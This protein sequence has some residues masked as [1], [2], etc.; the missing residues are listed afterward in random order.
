MARTPPLG[1][2]ASVAVC[3][4]PV[5]QHLHL[6]AVLRHFASLAGTVS[7]VLGDGLELRREL[8]TWHVNCRCIDQTSVS[9]FMGL[10]GGSV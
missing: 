3:Q 6:S 2:S 10:V 8:T 5:R 7:L 1:A 9:W 4:L